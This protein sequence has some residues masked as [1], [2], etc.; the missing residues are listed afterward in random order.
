MVF[1]INEKKK[2]LEKLDKEISELKNRIRPL[3]ESGDY[4]GLLDRMEKRIK[5]LEET[6]R[7]TKRKKILRDQMDYKTQSQRNWKEEIRPHYQSPGQERNRPESRSQQHYMT[8]RDAL[9]SHHPPIR[10]YS[11]NYPYNGYGYTRRNDN[12]N[13]RY[14][15]HNLQRNAMY[16]SHQNRERHQYTQTPHNR[17][18]HTLEK[19]RDPKQQRPT[20][21]RTSHTNRSP[22]QMRNRLQDGI[23]V[24]KYVLR[25]SHPMYF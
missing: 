19:P 13:D 6:I 24:S 3:V 18:I 5:D 4:V 12:R 10:T 21:T 9:I 22:E 17:R 25:T 2:D 16:R 11:R 15:Q 8:Y 14:Q 7:E 20:P 1:L 23:S